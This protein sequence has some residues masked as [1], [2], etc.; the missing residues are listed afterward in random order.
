MLMKLARHTLNA[1]IASVAAR[2]VTAALR[3]HSGLRLGLACAMLAT[4]LICTPAWSQDSAP[5]DAANRLAPG[6]TAS[7]LNTGIGITLEDFF[8]SA[9]EYSPRLQVAEERWNIGGARRRGAN[10]QLLPQVSASASI[11]DNRQDQP[12][13][14]I[15]TYRG[16]RYSLQ[17]R[18]VL[19]DWRVFSQRGQAYLL[20]NQYEAEYYAEL[21]AL[22]ADVA[23]RYLDVLQAEDAYASSQAELEAISTQLTQIQRMYDLQ[24][25]QVTDL[26]AVQAQLAAVEAEQLYLSSE[27]TITRE[28][29]RAATGLAVGD[30]YTLGEQSTVPTVEGSVEDW[31]ARARAGNHII[32]AREFAVEAAD[33][34][35]SEQRG[36]YL[37]RVS[38][39]VQQQRSD[40]GYD[41]AAGP[42]TETG[43]VGLDVTVPLFAG[44]S[45]RA[46]VSEAV[47]Q[48]SIARSELRQ[49]NLDVSEQT[50]LSYLRLKSAERQIDAAQKL[51]ESRELSATARRRGFELGAVTSVD[52]LDAVRDQFLAE[53]DL[54]R[55]RYEYL[56]LSLYLRRDAGSLTSDDLVEISSRLQAPSAP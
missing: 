25:V 4:P 16:E 24:M 17:L 8:T 11:S 5:A 33:R 26:Y 12:G 48:Q 47:S 6:V 31:V 21:A 37:P 15:D 52:V 14:P 3:R 45:T 20:E 49:L 27:V 19:F 56:K 29:L 35:V 23:E 7:S 41:N 40:L 36:N 43:Y 42:I 2:P 28:A 39:I 38:L 10:G 44:G 1:S 30:L 50:R 55:I 34:R 53:R 32:R 46:A 51:L 22:L 13:R 54:L 18:Q 9:M